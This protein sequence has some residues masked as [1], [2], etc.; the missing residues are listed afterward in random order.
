MRSLLSHTAQSIKYWWIYTIFGV[1]L[2]AVGV[3]IILTPEES[4]KGFG[5]LF[6]L[7]VLTKWWVKKGVSM[8]SRDSCCVNFAV[9]MMARL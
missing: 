8:S 1:M 6:S 7:T 4:F 2:M 5:I 3:F 9:L